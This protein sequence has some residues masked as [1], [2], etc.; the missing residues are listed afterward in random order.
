MV[1]LFRGNS[2]P[3]QHK[4]KRALAFGVKTQSMQVSVERFSITSS[5]PFEKIVTALDREIGHPE[6]AAFSKAIAAAPTPSELESV[7]PGA[8]GPL[9]LM[10]FARFDIGM[11]LRK[12]Q[13]DKAR[14]SL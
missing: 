3:R 5:Q 14:Q 9:G 10:E 12:E 2:V 4:K 1:G 6:L 13:G 7:V 11:V 8:T